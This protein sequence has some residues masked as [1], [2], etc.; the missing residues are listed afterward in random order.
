MQVYS[1]KS[2]R[3]TLPRSASAV[4]GVEFTQRCA[5]R[6]GMSLAARAGPAAAVAPTKSK[7][8]M[9]FIGEKSVRLIRKL[10]RRLASAQH[11]EEIAD[12]R[13]DGLRF[14]PGREVSTTGVIPLL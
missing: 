6:A 8:M 7:G 14:F 12:V 9:A 3:T 13:G 10:L 4:S 1:Q 11:A 5:S 2:T